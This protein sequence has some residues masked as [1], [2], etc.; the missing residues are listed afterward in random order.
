MQKEI[1]PSAIRQKNGNRLHSITNSLLI[2]SKK[3]ASPAT[4]LTSR[5]T[6]CTGTLTATC[7]DAMAPANGNRHAFDHKQLTAS[8]GR[9]CISCHKADRPNDKLHRDVTASC[10]ACHG[11]TKWKPAYIQPQTAGRGK[12][13]ISCHKADRPNDKLHREMTASCAA[14]HGTTKWK[15]A[16]IQPQT[17]GSRKTVHHLPQG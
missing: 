7:A 5:M 8:G 17:T 2:Q 14:C 11:T 6:S 4:R 15:P 3:S 16:Y 13:C 10:A 12:Q 9:Q 1:A